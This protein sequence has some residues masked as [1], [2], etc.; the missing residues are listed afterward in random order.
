M[1]KQ[2]IYL[3]RL[4]TILKPKTKTIQRSVKHKQF[5][6]DLEKNNK[7]PNQMFSY[8]FQRRFFCTA[9][10]FARTVSHCILKAQDQRLTAS[11][12]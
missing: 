5:T 2:K 8:N 4:S 3:K 9:Y 11:S 12:E 1:T 7:R 6:Q 10:G